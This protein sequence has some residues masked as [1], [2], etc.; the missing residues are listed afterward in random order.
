MNKKILGLRILELREKKGMTM[1]QMAEALGMPYSTYWD[2]ER[3]KSTLTAER[4]EQLAAYHGV[5]LDEFMS[6][7]NPVLH[8]QDHASHGYNVIHTQNQQINTEVVNEKLDRLLEMMGRQ[9][10][11]LT[12]LV[13]NRA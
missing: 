8:M 10:E 7:D 5:S 3:G 4:L 1:E 11:L 12:E 9:I 2:L 13:R 6:F